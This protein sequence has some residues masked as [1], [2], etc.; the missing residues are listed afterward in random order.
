MRRS[1]KFGILVLL[2]LGLAGCVWLF[3][4]LQA[5]LTATPTSGPAPLNVTFTIA[6]TG[7]ITKWTLL[8]PGASR[9][10][11]TGTVPPPLPLAKVRSYATAGEY[12]ATLIV[13]DSRGNAS[14]APV[15]IYVTPPLPT[16]K[17]WIVVDQTQLKQVEV[18]YGTPVTFKANG[19]NAVYWELFYG[20]GNFTQGVSLPQTRSHTYILPSPPQTTSYTAVLKVYDGLNRFDAD[21][22]EVTVTPP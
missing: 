19:T 2:G 10:Y 21:A 17:L 20:D 9:E 22:V 14:T 3:P 5:V 18:P 16:A 8:T 13:E 1:L 12:T 6:G 7:P 4:P 15:T 11:E